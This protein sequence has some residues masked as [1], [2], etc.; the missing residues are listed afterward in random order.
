MKALVDYFKKVGKKRLIVMVFGNIFLGMGIGIFKYAGMGNDPYSGMVMSLSDIAGLSYANFLVLTNL[1]IFLVEFVFG[2]E[3][4]GAGT[5]VNAFFLGYVATFFYQ[6]LEFLHPQ[7]EHL[8]VKV[9]VVLAGTL[10][11]GFGVSLYQTPN[12]G[13]SPYDSLSLILEKRISRLPY[14]WCRIITDAL[15]SLTCFLTG[16][17]VGLGTLISALGL[18]PVI[19]FVTVHFTRKLFRGDENIL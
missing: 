6:F 4:V 12:V 3:F 14:F 10:V 1:V 17:L 18:G 2:R 15:C 7:P 8:A 9:L 19:D 13:V 5:I 16:G 11:S